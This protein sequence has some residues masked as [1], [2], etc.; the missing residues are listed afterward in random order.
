MLDCSSFLVAIP[1]WVAKNKSL[2]RCAIPAFS[3]IFTYESKLS[4]FKKRKSRHF[5][6]G[7][8]F[9]EREELEPINFL[10]FIIR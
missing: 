1:V 5:M 6:P 8:C 10:V 2:S 9:A 4:T 7:F 3:F